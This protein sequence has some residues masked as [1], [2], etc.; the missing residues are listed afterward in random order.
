MYRLIT[1][2]FFPFLFSPNYSNDDL[3]HPVDRADD[4]AAVGD[5]VWQ[6]GG[7]LLAPVQP[8]RDGG[9]RDGRLEGGQRRSPGT[10]WL[11]QSHLS[12]PATGRVVKLYTV[13]CTIHIH[14]VIEEG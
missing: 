9:H 8:E 4:L 7:L 14:T 12:G 6:H 2:P 5:A 1:N 13:Q 10:I 11:R 3:D